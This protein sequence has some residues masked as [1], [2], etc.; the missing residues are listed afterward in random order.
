M[1][2]VDCDASGIAIG[3]ILDQEG[4]PIVYFSK[5]LNDKKRKYDSYD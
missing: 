5:K 1:P 2:Q 4:I 3:S